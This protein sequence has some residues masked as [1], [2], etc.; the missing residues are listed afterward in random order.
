MAERRSAR[1]ERPQ[2]RPFSFFRS[3]TIAFSVS[4]WE[5]PTLPILATAPLISKMG[6]RE[7]DQLFKLLIIG[8]SG[9][10]KTCLLTRYTDNIMM[11][12][13]TATI[14]VDFKVKTLHIDGQAIRL[15]I[16]DTAGQERFRTVCRSYYRG[17]QGIVL[18]YD[19]TDLQS[20]QNVTAAWASEITSNA[21]PDIVKLLV[22]T[23]SD[24][25]TYRVVSKES[26]Q[27]LAK[28][29][30]ALFIEA[31]ALDGTNVAEAFE[32]IAKQISKQHA[33]AGAKPKEDNVKKINL[34]DVS[35]RGGG[36]AAAAGQKKG[37]A[38]F[39]LV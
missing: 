30:N 32:T 20:F 10:G 35:P 29:I 14:G 28:S 1:R 15:Q 38:R 17:A 8:D 4:L 21:P 31:S 7:Y 16:W 3:R 5:F 34:G 27:D 23:K 9:V 2:G 11:D 19:V 22:G 37:F 26:G 12:T 6:A 18:V 39:C 33:A 24:L 13:Y 36:G 25:T